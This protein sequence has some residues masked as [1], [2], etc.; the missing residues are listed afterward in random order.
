MGRR[1]F[2][3]NLSFETTWQVGTVLPS[4]NPDASLGLVGHAMPAGHAVAASS[5]PAQHCAHNAGFRL[6][7]CALCSA[8]IT[9][10]SARPPC[11]QELKDHFKQAGRVAHADILAVRGPGWWRRQGGCKQRRVHGGGG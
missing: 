10:L 7:P 6:G 1:V 8:L 2:V 4:R 9:S 3:G 5:Q 11:L